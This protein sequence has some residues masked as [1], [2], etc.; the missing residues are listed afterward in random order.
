VEYMKKE[1]PFRNPYKIRGENSKLV[2]GYIPLPLAD[3]LRLLS[4]YYERSAQNLLREIIE[5]WNKAIGKSEEEIIETLVERAVVEWQ[6]RILESG[7]ISRRA[8]EDYINE[9]SETLARKKV[10]SHHIDIILGKL[11][12][13]VGSIE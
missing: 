2:G 9:L 8:Q 11:K 7:T 12:L 13:K 3:R 10:A 6:R 4:V 1:N 5:E